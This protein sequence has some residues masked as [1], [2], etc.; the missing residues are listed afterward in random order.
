MPEVQV[1]RQL[2]YRSGDRS[3]P[4]Y[5]CIG[6]ATLFFQSKMSCDVDG[7]PNAYHSVNDDLALDT[8]NS[9]EGAR[10]QGR[11][12]G[13]LVCPPCNSIVAYCGGKPYVQPTGPFQG[14]FVS[15]TTYECPN[16]PDTDPRRY[17]DARNIPYV[18]LPEGLVPEAQIGDLAAVY[19]PVT[20]RVTYAVYGDMGPPTECGEASLATL[21]N[22]GASLN[23]GKTSPNE[24][25]HDLFYLVFPGTKRKL[26]H[27]M[28]WPPTAKRIN[29]LGLAALQ[30]WGGTDRIRTLLDHVHPTDAPIEQAG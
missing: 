4:L 5:R 26:E 16:Y 7:A 1:L 9:A 20:R 14:F 24:D 21:K 23:D 2:S 10:L 29:K 25:R 11:S 12:A 15:R 13:P 30:T 8:I 28:A 6:D 18:V 17:L 19:D 3:V 22:L 27:R